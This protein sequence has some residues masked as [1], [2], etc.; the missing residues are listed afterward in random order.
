MNEGIPTYQLLH[1]I[2]STK[3]N[4]QTSKQKTLFFLISP[5]TIS[6]WNFRMNEWMDGWKYL[7]KYTLQNRI[8][9]EI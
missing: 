4:K 7:L 3:T 5:L 1:T 2:N 9:T 6:T 8:N